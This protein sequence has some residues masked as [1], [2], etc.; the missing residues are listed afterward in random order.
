MK[1]K[2][3][4]LKLRKSYGHYN[5]EPSLHDGRSFF[6]YK[7]GETKLSDTQQKIVDRLVSHKGDILIPEILDLIEE[8]DFPGIFYTPTFPAPGR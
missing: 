5:F 1:E 2:K 3:L 8:P 6:F 7:E 4:A